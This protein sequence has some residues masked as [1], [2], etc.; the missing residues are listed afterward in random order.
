MNA[1]QLRFF[2]SV[3]GVLL[4]A[5]A[6]SG[7]VQFQPASLYTGVAPAPIPER[8]RALS[9]A[10]EPVIYEDQNDDTIWFQDDTN[11]TQGRL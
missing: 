2:P 11:C 1:L 8:P 3:L 7:C 6:V 5:L 9:L 10:V 4:L